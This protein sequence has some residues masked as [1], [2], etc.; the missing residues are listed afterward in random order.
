[1]VRLKA[2]TQL[3]ATASTAFQ[4]LNG[5]IKSQA[6]QEYGSTGTMF[7]FLNGAIKSIYLHRRHCQ[8]CYFNSSMVRLKVE[9]HRVVFS[10]FIK[11]SIPQWCD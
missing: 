2:G 4:F 6:G 10:I 3:N 7:Q 8:Y 11:I 5:A 1:M 9:P